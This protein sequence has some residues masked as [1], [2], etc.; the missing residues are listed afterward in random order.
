MGFGNRRRSRADMKIFLFL[1]IVAIAAVAAAPA[2]DEDD[3][4]SIRC[5][6]V[7]IPPGVCAIL[8]DDENC[9]HRTLIGWKEEL[10]EGEKKL[11]FSHNNDAESVIVREGCTFR[12]YDHEEG[13]KGWLGFADG[14]DQVEE[15]GDAI[16]VVAD[17]GNKAV[18]F[19]DSDRGDE[20]DLD[21]DISYVSCRCGN[22]ESCPAVPP[23]LCAIAYDKHGCGVGNWKRPFEVAEVREQKIGFWDNFRESNDIES[24][25]VRKGCTFVGY[26][27]DD[28]KGDN[29][30][31]TAGRGRDEHRD[32]LG[33]LRNDISS[34]T[35]ICA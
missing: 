32:I 25:S 28:R 9:L 8:Y 21:D 2:A 23:Y 6:K 19:E 15:R 31:I 22:K 20:E 1:A 13:F 33:S 10:P 4:D 3:D 5:R 12:G 35:C 14:E 24:V 7:Q 29:V 17:N 26:D 34:I 27:K 30:T 11:G 16:V 18:T